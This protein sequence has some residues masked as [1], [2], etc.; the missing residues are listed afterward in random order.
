MAAQSERAT[1]VGGVTALCIVALSI[2][3]ALLSPS[4]PDHSYLF[5][6][7]YWASSYCFSESWVET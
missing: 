2:T 6:F 3:C 1:G 5:F 7:S 4:S